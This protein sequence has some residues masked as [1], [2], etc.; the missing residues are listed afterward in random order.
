MS[1][2]LSVQ[3]PFLEGKIVERKHV[4]HDPSAG[5]LVNILEAAKEL[6]R[7]LAVLPREP[8]GDIGPH[9][10]D[11][12]VHRVI[13]RAG[14]HGEAFDLLRQHPVK[15]CETGSRMETENSAPDLVDSDPR[16]NGANRCAAREYRRSFDQYLREHQLPHLIELADME[17]NQRTKAML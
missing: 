5:T 6:F 1:N 4:S 17:A 13:A 14:V 9:P 8:R 12:S 15:G 2:I 16:R 10:A 7:R 11:R 3:Q